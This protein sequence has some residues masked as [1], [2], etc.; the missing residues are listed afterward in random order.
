MGENGLFRS[1]NKLILFDTLFIHG[2]YQEESKDTNVQEWARIE[3]W[4]NLKKQHPV[5]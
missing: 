1:L 2:F 5:I 4:F 3:F